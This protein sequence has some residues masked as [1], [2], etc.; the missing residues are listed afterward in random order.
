VFKFSVHTTIKFEPLAETV[1]VGWQVVLTY[2]DG[3][4]EHV[5]GF[6]SE[7]EAVEFL[8]AILASSFDQ[9]SIRLFNG[10]L[11]SCGLAD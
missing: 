3:R 7:T 1:G 6:K 5:R 11:T 9:R 2:P 4:E 8:I 10:R